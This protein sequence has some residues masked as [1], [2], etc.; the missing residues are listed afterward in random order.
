MKPIWWQSVRHFRAI[1]LAAIPP[2]ARCS[3]ETGV[4]DDEC[5]ARLGRS[6][7]VEAKLI[8]EARARIANGHRAALQA[9]QLERQSAKLM[10]QFT[11]DPATRP[12]RLRIR[13]D[14]AWAEH[15]RHEQIRI[16]ELGETGYSLLSHAEE[17]VV[18]SKEIRWQ[19]QETR[20]RSQAQR[21]HSQRLRCAVRVGPLLAVREGSL[22][23]NKVVVPQ[24]ICC[25]ALKSQ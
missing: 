19:V 14:D 3:R 20:T 10:P 21:E 6:A 8:A 23:S 16:R 15:A 24:R 1:T 18:A 25:R 11:F 12:P 22:R 5:N 17:V 9:A 7:G 4:H 2:I 13:L